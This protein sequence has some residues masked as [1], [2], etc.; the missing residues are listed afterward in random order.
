[1]KKLFALLLAIVMLF[2][3]SY[4]T[5][6][7]ETVYSQG[8][9]NMDGELKPNAADLIL[10]RQVLLGTAD[11]TVM[12]NVNEDESVDI[13]DLV[14]LKK[15]VISTGIELQQGTNVFDYSVTE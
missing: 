12:A 14:C 6:S 11:E 3:F 1:M 2:S 13:R 15:I 7:A 8:D 9:V 5:V 10:L 4:M